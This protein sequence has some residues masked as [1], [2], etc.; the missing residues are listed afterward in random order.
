MFKI[1]LLLVISI[2]F[3]ISGC[4]FKKD[5][6]LVQ[7]NGQNIEIEQ[8]SSKSIEYIILTQDRLSVTLYQDPAQGEKGTTTPNLGQNMNDKGLLVNASGNI[9]LPLIGIVKV[10]GLTQT[11][12]ANSITQRYKKYMTA[13]SVYI[14]VLNKRIFVL[15]EVNKP[16]VIELDK[17]KMTLFEAIA[18]SG[19]L[20]DSAVRSDIIIL[21]N[22]PNGGMQMRK[23]DLTN[24]DRMD[25]ASLM[26][27]PNDV[28]YVK[29]NSWKAFRV[30][31]DDVTAPFVTFT[32]IASP[33]I[34]LKYL[35]D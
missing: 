26:L 15:G 29:P 2:L 16:G 4:S 32:K 14:E 17:E 30:A 20:T 6:N 10:A 9:S 28:V 11:E 1:K 18:H 5:Y 35:F 33:F 8:L 23:V 19:D 24:F 12:A 21:S 31:S 22:R 27:R 7:T 3:L 25:Y 13:P 34:T